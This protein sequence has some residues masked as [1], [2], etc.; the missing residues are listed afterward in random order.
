MPIVRGQRFTVDLPA[1]LAAAARKAGVSE[2]VSYRLVFVQALRKWLVEAG[3]YRRG[4]TVID[5]IARHHSRAG[6]RRKMKQIDL[7]FA[8]PP[9]GG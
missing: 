4:A 1:D 7:S 6:I 2:G 8:P 5:P 9:P 3:Y